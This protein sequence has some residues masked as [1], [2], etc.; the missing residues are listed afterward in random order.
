MRCA[1]AS[2]AGT[3][4]AGTADA[5]PVSHHDRLMATL[6]DID[7]CTGCGKCVEVCRKRTE[8][9]VPT[10]KWDGVPR[11]EEGKLPRNWSDG[12]RRED[13]T[14]L[15]PYTWLSIQKIPLETARG[16]R[17][18]YAPRRCM[19]CIN[20]SC[21]WMCPSGALIREPNGSVHLLENLCIGAGD[22]IEQCPWHIPTRQGG[23]TTNPLAVAEKSRM[24]KCDYCHDLQDAGK[25]P[26]CVSVCSTEAM[27]FGPY[28]EIVEKAK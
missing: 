8:S 20:P 3:L 13:T 15:T 2:L 21:T 22:C 17:I 6:I 28:D 7:A 26:L 5:Q 18:L 4:A 12:E 10:P 23:T 1:T 25:I 19:H 27:R 16:T 9:L 24:F 14:R 11:R